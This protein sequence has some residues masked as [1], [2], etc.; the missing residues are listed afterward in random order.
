VARSRRGPSERLPGGVRGYLTLRN[1]PV[2]GD[3]AERGACKGLAPTDGETPHPFFPGRGAS[4]V[5]A[6]VAELCAGCPVRVHCIGY[7][8]RWPV[9]GVWAA[10][11]ERRR[12]E[13]RERERDREV[14]AS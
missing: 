8:L 5:P 7:A 12:I 14:E 2:P 11:P 10:T 3:W 1:T 6:W 13:Y 9:L 4:T